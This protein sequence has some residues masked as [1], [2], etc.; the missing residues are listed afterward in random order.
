MN[1][2]RPRDRSEARIDLAL[3]RIQQI[4]LGVLVRRLR[5]G[6]D[7]HARENGLALHLVLHAD[8]GAFGHRRMRAERFLDLARAQP[9]TRHVDDIVG[10]P[11]DRDE[12]RRIHGGPIEGRVDHVAI[13]VA[14]LKVGLHEARVVAPERGKAPRRQRRTNRE[15]ALALAVLDGD[16]VGRIA[17]QRDIVARARQARRAEFALQCSA[18]GKSS[19]DRPAGF[20]LPVVV[21]H[22]HVQCVLD[23]LRR[24]H[25]ERLTREVKIT[26][27]A[28][29]VFSEERRILPA[30]HANGGGRREHHHRAIVLDD[31]PPDAGVRANRQPLV[32]NAR[33][34]L[35]E[36]AVHTVGMPD[37]PADVGGAEIRL[38]RATRINR[39][40]RVHQRDRRSACVAHDALGRARRARGVEDVARVGGID[41]FHRT[42]SPEWRSSSTAR[43][44]SRPP[45]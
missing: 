7:H 36:R 31:F 11:E 29:V 8:H 18:A 33:H 37:L 45:T 4:P 34:A 23:P 10:A 12:S 35:H 42:S 2:V 16:R 1:R 21:D 26:Q 3:E 19:E 41:R 40:H 20:G 30:Q 14:L 6:L 39:L 32:E 5:V 22:R 17:D 13:R 25:V 27:R 44:T 28:R 38:A 15:H 24:R 43:L 9:M